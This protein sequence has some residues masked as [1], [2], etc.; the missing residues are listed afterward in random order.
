[1]SAQSSKIVPLN[2]LSAFGYK[3][4]KAHADELTEMLLDDYLNSIVVD[5]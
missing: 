2:G 3:F 1:L 4:I 5:L